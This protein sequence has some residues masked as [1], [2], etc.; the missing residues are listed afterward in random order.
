MYM[1]NIYYNLGHRRQHT[2]GHA[3]M[4]DEQSKR[5]QLWVTDDEV[6]VDLIKITIE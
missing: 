4:S 3:L 5:D 2:S 1:V 6:S